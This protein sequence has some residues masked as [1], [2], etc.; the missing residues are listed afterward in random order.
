MLE[1]SSAASSLATRRLYYLLDLIAPDTTAG[2][3]ANRHKAQVAEDRIFCEFHI[4]HTNP[5]TYD[6]GGIGAAY[7]LGTLL[8]TCG[9]WDKEFF[10]TA[11]K[12]LSKSELPPHA[13]CTLS[14][15][16]WRLLKAI[17]GD[18]SRWN[19]SKL[20]DGV[21]ELKVDPESRSWKENLNL[22]KLVDAKWLTIP[23]SWYLE[24]CIFV[25]IS[26]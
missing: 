8:V 15:P 16:S 14:E 2:N 21:I 24:V 12:A 5:S 6:S 1:P 26:R 20:S 9:S 23:L 7:F 10:G 25:L 11:L 13:Q 17:F 4:P 19:Q 22:E 3:S 18:M